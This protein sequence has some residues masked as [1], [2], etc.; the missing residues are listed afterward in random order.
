MKELIVSEKTE[1]L[2]NRERE[3]WNSG[4]RWNMVQWE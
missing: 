3:R 1:K 4:K 2:W